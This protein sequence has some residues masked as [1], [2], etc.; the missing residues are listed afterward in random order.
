MNPRW[1][2]A[3]EHYG[4]QHLPQGPPRGRGA[5]WA[6]N[7]QVAP[8]NETLHLHRAQRSSHHR[9]AADSLVSGRRVRPDPG[10]R[11]RRWNGPVGRD[12]TPGAGYDRNRSP[13]LRNAFRNRPLVGR[14]PHQLAHDE[15]TDRRIDQAGEDG[16]QRRIGSADQ[17]GRPHPYAADGA[18]APSPGGHP[19][20]DRVAQPG[21]CHRRPSRIHRRARI[22]HS[23]NPSGRPGGYELRSVGCGLCHSLQR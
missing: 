20:H 6:S 19:Q 7:P 23:E 9:P 3:K 2:N 5:L 17:K 22:Q 14:D 10:Y 11:C 16:S 4:C 1:K 21:V 18:P 15:G 13:A 12:Q 8:E